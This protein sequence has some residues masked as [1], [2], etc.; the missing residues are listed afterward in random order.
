MRG[1]IAEGRF[2]Q[3]TAEARE[4]LATGERDNDSAD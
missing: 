4:R 2:A 1:A 3:W